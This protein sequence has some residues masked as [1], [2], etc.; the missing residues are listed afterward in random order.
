SPHC[1]AVL[2]WLPAL[3]ALVADLS[4]P[5]QGMRTLAFA[6]V[7]VIVVN[8]TFSFWQEY[9]AEEAFLALQELLPAE[10]TTVR[11][12]VATRLPAEQLVPG[13]VVALE[14]GDSIPADCRVLPYF[15]QTI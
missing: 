8:G 4:Q 2:L 6:I 13:D 15:S 11:D 7:A 12:G 9:R 3:L 1:V 14:A 10:V 5:G